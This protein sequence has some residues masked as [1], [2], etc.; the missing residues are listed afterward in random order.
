MKSQGIRILICSMLYRLRSF[1]I[2]LHCQLGHKPSSTSCAEHFQLYMSL[3]IVG[4]MT[5]LSKFSI[6]QFAGGTLSEV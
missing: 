6:K 3:I 1:F 2:V 5:Q 4:A